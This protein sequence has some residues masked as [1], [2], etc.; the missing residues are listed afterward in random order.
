MRICSLLPGATEVIAGFGL[1]DQLVGISHECDYPPEVHQKPVVIRARIDAA[2]MSSAEVDQH[3]RT[4]VE[5]KDALYTIDEALLTELQPNL[6]IAQDLCDVCAITPSQ[7]QGVLQRLPGNCQV[8]SLNPTTLDGIF[9]AIER[10]GEAVE[11]TGQARELILR[12]RT[13]LTFVENTVARAASIPR[14]VCL[15]WLDPLYAGGHWVPEMI[16]LAGGQDILGKP[17]EPSFRIAWSEP[18]LAQADI[19]ILAPCGFSVE[20]TMRELPALL[21]HPQ[22]S[23]LPAV[24]AGQVYVLDASAYMSRP[25]PRL[26]DGVELLARTFHPDLFKPACVSGVRRLTLQTTLAPES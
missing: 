19:L 23:S 6:V 14:V 11:Q 16:V 15:E 4:A 26:I 25:G 10:I 18:T 12:L 13:R 9:N 3:V 1:A 21:A 20:R 8:L 17:A 2:R 5:S 24:Q 7:L 22:W